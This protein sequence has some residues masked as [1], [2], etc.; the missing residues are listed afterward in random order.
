LADNEGRHLRKERRRKR[1]RGGG[2]EE[3]GEREGDGQN[4]LGE[5]K[6]PIGVLEPILN[7]IP[8]KGL[9]VPNR[10]GMDAGIVEIKQGRR[11]TSLT[12]ILTCSAE[13]EGAGRR[14]VSDLAE[15]MRESGAEPVVI[16]PVVLLPV[17]SS[18]DLVNHLV[19][20]ISSAAGDL[21]IVIGKGHTEITSR[22]G[23][24]TIIATMLGTAQGES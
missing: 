17:G 6:L 13:E 3:E 11:V 23:R 8:T 19:S 22:V 5:G 10:I 24:V 9:P 4:G 7:S 20:E 16:N 12:D 2:E 15:R 14:L 21:G 18:A 1:R